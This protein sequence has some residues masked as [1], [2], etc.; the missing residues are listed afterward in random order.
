VVISGDFAYVADFSSSFTVA[1]ISDPANP[2]LG[3]STPRDT[4]GLLVDVAVA[5]RFAFGADVF[6]VNGV[7]IIDVDIP[8]TPT[9]RAILDLSSSTCS[10]TRRP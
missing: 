2:V 6:F 8:Q 1:N 7:P 3:N 10:P 5:G 9:P 4:G